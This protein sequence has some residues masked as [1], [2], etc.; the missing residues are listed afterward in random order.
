MKKIYL[1]ILCTI[2]VLPLFFLSQTVALGAQG[3][4][5]LNLN[6]TSPFKANTVLETKE[7]DGKVLTTYENLPDEFTLN[8]DQETGEQGISPLC[9]SCNQK[10][11]TKINTWTESSDYNFGWH[12][13][14]KDY[15]R[16]SGYWFSTSTTSFG[17]SVSYGF[18][19][20]SISSAGGNGYYVNADYNRW[21]RPAVYGKYLV[22][23]YKVDEYN[24]AGIYLKT[25]YENFPSAQDTYVKILYK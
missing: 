19:S 10:V 8:V 22:T 3:D 13:G 20:V 5:E 14:F 11:Y 12:P 23:K 1:S 21:S 4:V 6:T 18:L 24:P 7:I 15:N 16:A 25:Y 17:V 9:A 2:L